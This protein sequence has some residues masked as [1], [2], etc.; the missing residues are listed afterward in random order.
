MSLRNRRV[1]A[2][3]D[4]N[5]YGKG[6]IMSGSAPLLAI[7]LD[8]GGSRCRAAVAGPDG[9]VLGRGEA[10]A[11]NVTTD[12]TEATRNILTAAAAALAAAQADAA[13]VGAVHA[14]LAG[15]MGPDDA[16]RVAA[17]LP[18]AGVAV[19]DDRPTSVA[20]ALGARDGALA[21]VG[22]GSF[23]AL[24]RGA[25]LRCVG[26]WGAEVGDQ[27]SGAWLGRAL[28]EH[29]LL[30]RDGLAAETGLTRETLAA[31]G[32]DPNAIVRFAAAARPADLAGHAPRVADAA[33]AGDATGLALM[34]RGAAYL[35]QALDAFG[36]ARGEVLCLTGGLGPRYAAFLAEDHRARIAPPDGDALHGAVRLA[37][38]RLA[39]RRGAA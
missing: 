25:A 18:F 23:V 22:T 35:G 37:L 13:A 10:G 21:A 7:G 12:F 31:F 27:A 26:G 20:G 14:G 16:A 5:R 38:A 29:V 30:A 6:I 34:R 39:A 8:G 3:P 2:F 28:L 36:L 19:T 17:A 15:V 4:R 11:A 24:K 9:R 1:P 32:G 33:D